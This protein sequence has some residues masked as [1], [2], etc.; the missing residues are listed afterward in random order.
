MR[1]FKVYLVLG[2]AIMLRLSLKKHILVGLRVSWIIIT[3]IEE[4]N[5]EF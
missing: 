1:E 2:K 4:R 3:I 5:H